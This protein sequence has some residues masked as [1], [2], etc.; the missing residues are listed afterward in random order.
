MLDA[1]KLMRQLHNLNIWHELLSYITRKYDFNALKTWT[2]LI[3][4]NAA[5]THRLLIEG[6][7]YSTTEGQ[8][9]KYPQAAFVW[10]LI[11]L[12]HNDLWYSEEFFIK[13]LEK[14]INNDIQK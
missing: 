1:Q 4:E 3:E 8:G 9:K 7:K 5:K 14:V 11:Y 6:Q 2:Y 10:D 12:L 13:I